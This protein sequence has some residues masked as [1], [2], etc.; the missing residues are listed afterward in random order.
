MPENRMR[1][2]PPGEILRDSYGFT[3]E[4]LADRLRV[5]LEQARGLLLGTEPITYVI[6]STLALKLET[7]VAFWMGMQ[8]AFERRRETCQPPFDA[9]KY[10]E[11][12]T[13]IFATLTK[14]QEDVRF[15]AV[16]FLAD[17]RGYR[18]LGKPLTGAPYERFKDYVRP[19][20][21]ARDA[22]GKAFASENVLHIENKA[23][24]SLRPAD[25]SRFTPEEIAILDATIADI[26][27]KTID[28]A[29][30][31]LHRLDGWRLTTEGEEIPYFTALL[32]DGELTPSEDALRYGREVV[33]PMLTKPFEKP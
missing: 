1:P 20:K 27:G 9:T 6:A 4:A 10:I 31:S 16:L 2:I 23:F 19:G 29:K 15:C 25:L 21:V 33:A 32:A 26:A 12:L 18:E 14:D 17:R 28:E 3:P 13:H 30:A 7:T 22:F 8:D 24:Y 11:A 5:P